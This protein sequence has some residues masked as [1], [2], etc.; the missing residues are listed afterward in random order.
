M[1]NTH[2]AVTPYENETDGM[3]SEEADIFERK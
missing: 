2:A 1:S 3:E